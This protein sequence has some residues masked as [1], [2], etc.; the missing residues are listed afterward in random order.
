[1]DVF[2][3]VADWSSFKSI[4]SVSGTVAVAGCDIVAGM[5][6]SSKLF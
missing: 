1:M 3:D 4:L 5:P 2:K 6:V